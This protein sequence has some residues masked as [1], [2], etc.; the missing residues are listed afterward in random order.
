M[1]YKKLLRALLSKA[2]KLDA[3]QL[4]E[5]LAE[6][7]DKDGTKTPVTFEEL[8]KKLLDTDKTRVVTLTTP[9]AGST[10]QDGFA[11]GK[12][13]SLTAFEKE[14]K[15]KYGVDA[16]LLGIEL[17][18][19]VVTAKATTGGTLTDDDVKKHAVYVA[20]ERELKTELKN[21]TTELEG[22][23]TEKEKEFTKKQ[24]LG[25]I[26]DKAWGVVSKLNPLLSKTAE[27][28]QTQKNTFLAALEANEYD[29]QETGP[30]ILVDGK[31]KTD[32][33]GNIVSFDDFVT[34]NA[35]RF[36]DFE[37]NNGGSNGGND[38][39]DHKGGG[40]GG[41]KA[42][43]AGVTKPKTMEDLVKVLND[44]TIKVDDRVIVQEVWDKENT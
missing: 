22:K 43:P 12:K 6:E 30:V 25:I 19:A 17:I 41:A 9:K 34:G 1:D 11:K 37:N 18:D 42:Y 10:Y 15:D 2:Y 27:V 16:D 14:V 23:I 29:L 35:K 7:T 13:E 20:R 40:Q 24:N 4:D 26:K 32:D 28:A 33:H 31:A 39:N 5:L 36:F 38:N 3:G 8:E 21:K 44:K